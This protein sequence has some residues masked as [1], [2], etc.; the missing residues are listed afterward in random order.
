MATIDFVLENFAIDR[1]L[2]VSGMFETSTIPTLD[3]SATAYYYVSL[4]SIRNTF[5]YSESEITAN[6]V[7]YYVDFNYN[8]ADV[9]NSNFGGR[10]TTG[11][12]YGTPDTAGAFFF[13]PTLAFA[14]ESEIG[15]PDSN[16]NKRTVAHDYIRS[17]AV[18]L[19]N[20]YHGAS[21]FYNSPQLIR[22]IRD[23]FGFNGDNTLS[24]VSGEMQN[25]IITKLNDISM[26]SFNE[27]LLVDGNGYKYTNAGTLGNLQDN[28]TMVLMN[29]MMGSQPSRFSN[30]G[31]SN[32]VPEFSGL[33]TLPFQA[34]DTISFKLTIHPASGQ[35][36]VVSSEATV[37]PRSYKIQMILVPTS[38]IQDVNI[39]PV[40]ENTDLPV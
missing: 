31:D 34:N 6:V 20:T 19:F 30:L 37:H 1:T 16:K 22:D 18:D 23:Q 4:E 11:G 40:K 25:V 7:D 10:L 35:N 5:L 12:A 3:V 36:T 17:I 33:R 2:D 39:N 21:L 38:T 28:I 15:Y 24:I 26:Q 29:Q 27:D 13:N 32:L 9:A 14:E 8:S